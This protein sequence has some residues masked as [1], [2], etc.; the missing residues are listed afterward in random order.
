M[1][2]ALILGTVIALAVAYIVRQR[3]LSSLSAF[4]GPLLASISD[5]PR[6]VASSTGRIDDVHREWHQKYGSAVRIGPNTISFSDPKLIKT[7]YATKNAW[8]KVRIS[9]RSASNA[10]GPRTP[11]R[12]AALG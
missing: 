6:A 11:L 10:I 2:L 3:Y 1:A 4:P 7:I 5:V 12:F 9:P 8:R